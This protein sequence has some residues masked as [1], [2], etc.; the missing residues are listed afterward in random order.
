MKPEEDKFQ[1]QIN[2]KRLVMWAWLAVIVITLVL[3]FVSRRYAPTWF[4]WL[5]ILLFGMLI[6]GFMY[7]LWW[8]ATKMRHV[9]L[10]VFLVLFWY[11]CT[12]IFP[13]IVLVDLW[14]GLSIHP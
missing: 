12:I 11:G 7:F 10:F 3:L 4:T 13:A 2:N 6:P 1:F 14:Q 5:W 9:V 8:N